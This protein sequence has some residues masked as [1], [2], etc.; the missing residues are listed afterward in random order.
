MSQPDLKRIILDLRRWEPFM[1]DASTHT[2]QAVKASLAHT[3]GLQADS[4]PERAA[5]T[6]DRFLR[7]LQT[8]LD[9][10]YSTGWQ[11]T[12]S[13][14]AWLAAR[15]NWGPRNG[16]DWAQHVENLEQV[17]ARWERACEP[18]DDRSDW[19]CP[20]CGTALLRWRHSQKTY[21][22]PACDYNGDAR[23][24]ANMRRYVITQADTWITRAQA[25]ELYAS[26]GLTRTLLRKWIER[27]K[28]ETRDGLVS[29]Q[30][31]RDALPENTM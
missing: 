13:P 14:Y 17:H 20:A 28:I 7:D 19:L 26:K 18:A 24:V 25:I 8:I 2:L 4:Q 29:N 23:Q 12:G 5:F 21:V 16:P 27:E 6:K 31:I 22:C 11:D 1:R 9:A 10:A 15:A 30:N 3:T